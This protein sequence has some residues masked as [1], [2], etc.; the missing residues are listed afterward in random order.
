MRSAAL[1]VLAAAAGA[2]GADAPSPTVAMQITGFTPATITVKR[3][4]TVSFVNKDPYPHTATSEGHF[5][6]KEV[7][8]GK[9]WKYAAKQ[10]GRFDYICTLHPNMKGTLVVE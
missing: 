2:F 1:V 3:G 5:D 7:G 6:S 8:P 10:A 4:T 9:T